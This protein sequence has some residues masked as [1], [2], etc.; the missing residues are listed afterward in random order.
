MDAG[1]YYADNS[2]CFL[3]VFRGGESKNSNKR[4]SGTVWR[5]RA[6]LQRRIDCIPFEGIRTAREFSDLG[7]PCIASATPERIAGPSTHKHIKP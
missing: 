7:I 1:E 6:N 4:S 5:S 3:P 2:C